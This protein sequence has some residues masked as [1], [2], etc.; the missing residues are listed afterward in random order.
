VKRF[1]LIFILVL[2]G[3]L[4]FPVRSLEAP[5]WEVSVVDQANRPLKGVTV[6]ESFR[7]YSAESSG[8]EIDLITDDQ[9][10]VRFQTRSIRVSLL[11]R[12]LMA[13]SSATGE[14]TLALVLTPTSLRSEKV[15][16]AIRGRMDTLR[17]GLDLQEPSSR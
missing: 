16:K 11:T 1:R 17:I 7:N 2:G 10:K 4:L 5:L 14:Y 9:G 3:I 15:L 8:G 6:R 12:L 13:A